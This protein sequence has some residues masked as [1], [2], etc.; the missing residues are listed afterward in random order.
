MQRLATIY[1]DVRSI[2]CW[3]EHFL[4]AVWYWSYVLLCWTVL[5]LKVFTTKLHLHAAVYGQKAYGIYVETGDFAQPNSD[6]LHY[7]WYK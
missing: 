5:A 6:N 4:L 7:K 2:Y 3:Q 1:S